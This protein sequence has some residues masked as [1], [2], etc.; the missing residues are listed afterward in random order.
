MDFN[1]QMKSLHIDIRI[2]DHV[3]KRS[4]CID[5]MLMMDIV[6]DR[7]TEAFVLERGYIIYYAVITD[8]MYRK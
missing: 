5:G 7:N 8:Y 6:N 2:Y 4:G 3:S 1:V